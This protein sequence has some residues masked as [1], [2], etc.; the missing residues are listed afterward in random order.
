MHTFTCIFMCSLYGLI[1]KMRQCC[2]CT[3]EGAKLMYDMSLP[4]RTLSLSHIRQH[5]HFGFSAPVQKT[6]L[7]GPFCSPPTLRNTRTSSL[8]LQS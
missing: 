3:L 1:L 7:I 6:I 4:E 2:N 8:N 5:T